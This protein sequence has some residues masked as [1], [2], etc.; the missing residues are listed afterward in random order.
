MSFQNVEQ[1]KLHFAVLV[2]IFAS[3][4]SAVTAFPPLGDDLNE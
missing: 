4:V 2:A 1:K 3:L